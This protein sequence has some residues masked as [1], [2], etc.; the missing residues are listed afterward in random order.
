MFMKCRK[1]LNK[2]QSENDIQEKVRCEYNKP[3]KD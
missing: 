3:L 2:I 1:R